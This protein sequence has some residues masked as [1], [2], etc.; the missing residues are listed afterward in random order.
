MPK[1]RE[2]ELAVGFAHLIV[3][4]KNA[5]RFQHPPNFAEEPHFVG[6]IHADI[7][8][9]S[10]EWHCKGAALLETNLALHPKPTG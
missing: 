8:S 3:D 1:A 7:E 6:D 5:A 2:I 10:G 4:A 9:R